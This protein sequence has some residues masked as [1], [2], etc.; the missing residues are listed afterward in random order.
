MNTSIK[1][2]QYQKA[3]EL[4]KKV[5]SILVIT[6]AGISAD[7]GL[8]TYRGIGGVYEDKITED[9]LEIEEALSIEMFYQKP[10]LVWKYIKHLVVSSEGKTFNKAHQILSEL[11][12]EKD[13][14]WILTQNVDGFHIDAGSKNIIEI[15]GNL[16][17]LICYSC[18]YKKDVST[19]KNISLPP[20]CPVC[21]SIL[22][23]D[24]VLFGELLPI[25]KITLLEKELY[26]GFDLYIIIGT[27]GVFPYIYEPVFKAIYRKIP[28]IEINPAKTIFSDKVDFY[29]SERASIALSMIWDYYKKI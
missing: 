18:N 21:N 28:T 22:K 13:R 9:G 19:Y 7:S 16:R 15:H 20:H 10:E 17:R 3:A 1:L 2:T 12:K 29:F 27:S 11:E 23:P 24:V 6:G 26:I 25:E 5:N 4:I 8:P 14:F